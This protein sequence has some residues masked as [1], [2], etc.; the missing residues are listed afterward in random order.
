MKTPRE[1][2]LKRHQAAERKLDQI[3]KTAVAAVCDRH[4]D[5][6]AVADRRYC[7]RAFLFSLRWHLA[8]MSAA[9]LVI[10]LLTLNV[11][12]A[13]NLASAVPSGKIPPAQIILA[14]LRENR[15]E[16]LEMI[17]PAETREA[18]PVKLFPLQPRSERPYETLTA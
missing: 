8:G 12:H 7:W 10:A 1:I 9:W 16:L 5:S 14:S 11:G 15:R 17:Q 6:P 2:L 3:R 4:L 18:R 13:T